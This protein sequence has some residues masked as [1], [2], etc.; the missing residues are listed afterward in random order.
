MYSLAELTNI[1]PPEESNSE[2]DD[3][4]EEEEELKIGEEDS[5]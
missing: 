5:E 4:S 2:E 1:S 3:R